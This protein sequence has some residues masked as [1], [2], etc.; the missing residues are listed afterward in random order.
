MIK[1]LAHIVCPIEAATDFYNNVNK[2]IDIMQ[3][4]GLNVNIQYQQSDKVFS[5]IILGREKSRT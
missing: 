2:A 4:N 1:N 3:G 5:A